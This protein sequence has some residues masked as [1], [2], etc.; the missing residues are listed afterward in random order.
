MRG[1]SGYNC[2]Q[3]DGPKSRFPKPK[4]AVGRLQ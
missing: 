2:C 4:L 3:A 1:I